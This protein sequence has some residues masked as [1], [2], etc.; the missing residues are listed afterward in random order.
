MGLSANDVIALAQETKALSKEQLERILEVAPTMS[1]ADLEEL[2]KMILAVQAAEIE[3]MKKELELRQK[4]AAAY[5][6]WQADKARATLQ[7]QEGAVAREDQAQ[8]EIGVTPVLVDLS[9]LRLIM[10][11]FPCNDSLRTG[12]NFQAKIT[13]LNFLK[14]L[15]KRILRFLLRY[16]RL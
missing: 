14:S 7:T 11:S 13:L 10:I 1:A 16:K 9:L 12:K 2:K 3:G 6:E 5:S 4:V 8:F 15:P